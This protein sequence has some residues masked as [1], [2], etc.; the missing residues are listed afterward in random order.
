LGELSQRQ[1]DYDEAVGWF[2]ASRREAVRAMQ[3]PQPGSEELGAQIDAYCLF[4]LGCVASMRGELSAAA[5]TLGEALEKAQQLQDRTLEA[6]VLRAAS[7]V[8]W[9]MGEVDRAEVYRRRAML[10]AESFGDREALAFSSLHT[11]QHLRESGRVSEALVKGQEAH[12]VFEE[13]GKRHQ[14]AHCLLLLGELAWLRADYKEAAQLLRKAHRFYEMFKDRRGL[15]ECKFALASLAL[16][17]RRYPNTQTLARDAQEGYR[18]MG[19]RRGEALTWL[20]VGRLELELERYDRAARSFSEASSALLHL[21]DHRSATSARLWWLGAMEANAEVTQVDAMLVRI[22]GEA[23]ELELVDEATG[24]AYAYLAEVLN[25]RRP[26]VALDMD[27]CAERVWQR[28]GRPV[29]AE[30]APIE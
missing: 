17:I 5:L 27:E 23:E 3:F 16:S 6:D 12:Q 20:L 2:E 4:G 7:D 18:A 9:R 28:L 24:A 29:H 26:D 21:R 10:L 11:A 22:M 19:D 25:G 30:A 8:C 13:L 1:G 15:T 14:S